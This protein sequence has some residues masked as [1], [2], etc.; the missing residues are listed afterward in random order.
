MPGER[1]RKV[2]PLLKT[3]YYTANV[4]NNCLQRLYKRFILPTSSDPDSRRR[5]FILNVLLSGLAIASLVGAAAAIINVY[6]RHAPH[7]LLLVVPM[8]SFFGLVCA[9]LGISRKGHYAAIAV[10]LVS[11]LLIIAT[12]LLITWSFVLPSVPV[13]FVLSIMLAGVLFEARM[14]LWVSGIAVLV[15]LSIGLAQVQGI[16][17]P[18]TGWLNHELEAIDAVGN[19]ILFAVIGLVTWLANREIDR[20]LERARTSEHELAIERDSLEV[21]VVERTRELKA[22]Q[23]TRIMELQRL[24]EYGRMGMSLLHD[25]ANPLTAA[26][27]NIEQLQHKHH[28][29]LVKQISAS[30]HHIERYVE[31]ARKQLK[32]ESAISTFHVYRELQQVISII[33]HRAKEAKVTIRLDKKPRMLLRGDVVRFNQ[34]IANL[35]LNAIEAYDESNKIKRQVRVS[36]SKHKDTLSLTVQDWGI[37]IPADKLTTIFD[38]FFS[39]KNKASHN[40]GIGLSMVKRY[41]EQ[42]CGG[43]ITVHSDDLHGTR[44]VVLLPD[45]KESHASTNHS[46]QPSI[47][48]PPAS[49]RRRL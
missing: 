31:A 27:L 18:Y 5:E 1:H 21:K 36:Y 29:A 15:M 47:P 16:I 3:G 26:S 23:M 49:S 41:I 12:Y 6:S 11:S 22:A 2:A 37:G 20:S 32:T 38:P 14:A 42:D 7:E 46:K 17:T 10:L 40:M 25:V 19:A 28:P 24:S 39:T 8:I 33:Q 43:T 13:T 4:L 34:L 48:D 35:L 45:Y 44:F 9:C 30:V